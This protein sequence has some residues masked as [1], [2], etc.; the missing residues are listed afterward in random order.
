MCN[1][2]L[3]RAVELLNNNSADLDSVDSVMKLSTNDGYWELDLDDGTT[4]VIWTEDGF[5]LSI[6]GNSEDRYPISFND[7][8]GVWA[9]KAIALED[10]FVDSMQTL[11]LDKM[12]LELRSY[13]AFV[14]DEGFWEIECG[15]RGWMEYIKE[16][17][18]YVVGQRGYLSP[19]SKLNE[20]EGMIDAW[21]H[22]ERQE[23]GTFKPVVDEPR[24]A[25]RQ[26]SKRS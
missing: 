10:Q 13:D 25:K 14:N 17:G 24:S 12:S 1:F 8:Y 9:I 5:I 20:L 21:G 11:L 16:L 23:D 22:M 15:D 26:R 6:Y 7:D 19:F 2:N 3:I 4:S 18:C